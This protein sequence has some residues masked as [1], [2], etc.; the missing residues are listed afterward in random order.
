M[1]RGAGGG[2]YFAVGKSVAAAGRGGDLVIIEDPYSEQ[3]VIANPK[4]EFEK[5]WKWYLAGPRQ[6]LQPGEAILVVMTRWGVPDLTGKLSQQYIESDGD[7][8]ETWE[9]V[10]LPA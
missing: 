1:E 10:Q 2:Q 4:D 5:T 7:D 6:R 3:D 9:I 8:G